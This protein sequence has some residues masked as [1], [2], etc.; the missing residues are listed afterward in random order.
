MRWQN[1]RSRRP[2]NLQ[3]DNAS[4]AALLKRTRAQRI[5]FRP[6]DRY[7]NKGRIHSRRPI[8]ASSF[9]A[10]KTAADHTFRFAD[11]HVG[12]LSR[13]KTRSDGALRRARAAMIGKHCSARVPRGWWS[14]LS[15]R[16]GH[17]FA[18]SGSVEPSQMIEFVFSASPE[19]IRNEP[20]ECCSFARSATG[21]T[22]QPARS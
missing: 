10:C 13:E 12:Q 1:G 16:T 8:L 17:P 18:A 6:G 2:R 5:P 14:L 4:K 20:L 19:T 3:P 21:G 15:C 7:S 11:I 9:F 22:W